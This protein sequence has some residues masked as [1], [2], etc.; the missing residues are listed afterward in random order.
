MGKEITMVSQKA[1]IMD[2]NGL[3]LTIRRSKTAPSRPLY[4]DFPGGKLEYGEDIKEGILREIKEETGLNVNDSKVI[5]AIAKFDDKGEYWV[6]IC[7]LMHPTN[8]K[9]KLSYEHDDYKWI[10][11]EEFSRLRASPKNKK[12]AE[13]LKLTL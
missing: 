8:K 9:V 11:L 6:T 4:W 12:F 5:D 7:Y 2:N 13:R 1:I 3:I 10:T